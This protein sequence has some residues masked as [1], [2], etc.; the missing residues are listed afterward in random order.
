MHH[1]E[2]PVSLALQEA[3]RIQSYQELKK[4]KAFQN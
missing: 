3:F 4:G 2:N 1:S